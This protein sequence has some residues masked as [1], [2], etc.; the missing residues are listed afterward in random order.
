[1]K[2]LLCHLSYPGVI[3]R[4][5]GRD[6]TDSLRLRTPAL[7]Q[8][9]CEDMV[10]QAGFEPAAFRFVAGRSDSTELLGDG[11]GTGTRT[12]GS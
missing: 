5:L 3:S 10:S 6:R 9:S 12:L 7:V 2:P 1:M 11:V 4:V 8:S